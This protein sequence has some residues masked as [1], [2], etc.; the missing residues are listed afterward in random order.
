MDPEGKIPVN[1]SGSL[2]ISCIFDANPPNV[3]DI[4]WYKNGRPMNIYTSQRSSSSMMSNIVLNKE[5]TTLIMDGI[6]R[7]DSG[8]FSCHLKNAYGEGNATNQAFVDVWCKL[9]IKF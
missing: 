8:Y 3:S 9:I 1:E 4:V 6:T 7:N 2:R 5:S